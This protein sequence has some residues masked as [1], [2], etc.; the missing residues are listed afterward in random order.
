MTDVLATKT[1]HR[2]TH[3]GIAGRK[4]HCAAPLRATRQPKHIATLPRRPPAGRQ[5][6]SGRGHCAHQPQPLTPR[7]PARARSYLTSRRACPL[8]WRSRPDRATCEAFFKRGGDMIVP[9]AVATRASRLVG[10][11]PHDEANR[12][13]ACRQLC[14]SHLHHGSSES[15]SHASPSKSILQAFLRQ[16]ECSSLRCHTAH[17]QVRIG[18]TYHCLIFGFRVEN[19]DGPNIRTSEIRNTA[20]RKRPGHHPRV[21]RISMHGSGCK[22]SAGSQ[23][24]K[25]HKPS[26]GPTLSIARW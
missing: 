19:P 9:T 23:G 4:H 22:V 6:V 2:C 5:R 15:F 11:A 25:R 3:E 14:T 8:S 13:T 12:A 18:K 17:S 20:R 10:G 7:T 26:E 24:A 21:P 1:V 16:Y